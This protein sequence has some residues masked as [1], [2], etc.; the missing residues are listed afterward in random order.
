MS[1]ATRI[2]Q[3]HDLTGEGINFG[4]HNTFWPHKDMERPPPG[5]GISSMPCPPQRQHEHERRHTIHAPIHSNKTNMKGWLWRPHD[6]RGPCRRKASWHLSY[7]WGKTPKK[8]HPENLSRPG[9]EPG[10]AAWQARMLPPAPQRW[11]CS[12]KYNKMNMVCKCVEL[13]HSVCMFLRLYLE[14]H[15]FDFDATFDNQEVMIPVRF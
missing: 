13:C 3:S 12:N 7:R 5:W 9:I 8:S 14:N 10:P 11:T 6:I 4:S 2:L 15:W 1:H